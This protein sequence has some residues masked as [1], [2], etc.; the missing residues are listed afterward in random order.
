MARGLT[1]LCKRNISQGHVWAWLH[2][3]KQVPPEYCP[4]IEILTDG[5]VTRQQ[6]RPDVVWGGEQ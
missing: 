5:R 2:R 3:Y 1:T 6:L 4:A